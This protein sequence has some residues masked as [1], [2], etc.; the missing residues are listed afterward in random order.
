MRSPS[1][2]NQV[3]DFVDSLGVSHSDTLPVTQRPACYDSEPNSRV[4]HSKG[5]RRVRHI[6]VV[7]A[8][9]T[10]A[11][12]G[13]ANAADPFT[14]AGFTSAQSVQVQCAFASARGVGRKVPAGSVT[15]GVAG[16]PGFAVRLSPPW[17]PPNGISVW[18]DWS[19]H[20]FPA[21][22]HTKW[23][24]LPYGRTLTW[25][26]DENEVRCRSVRAY[27]SG[28]TCAADGPG[29]TGGSQSLPRA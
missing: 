9:G 6:A 21:T 25:K 26:W 10:L 27:T 24:P 2:A 23:A 16:N 19:Y 3:E 28:I 15:C 17:W 1:L 4:A 22:R 5:D 8:L 12:A 11:V 7:A 13:Q 29:G 14:S 18:G 20:I